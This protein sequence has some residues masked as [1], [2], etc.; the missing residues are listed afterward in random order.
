MRSGIKYSLLAVF[1][2]A[3]TGALISAFQEPD[4]THEQDTDIKYMIGSVLPD[5]TISAGDIN[6]API[7][8]PGTYNWYQGT[9]YC[10]NLVANNH[11]DWRLPTEAELAILY[12]NRATG[13]FSG[14]FND[15]QPFPAGIYWSS[16]NSLQFSNS[17]RVRYFNDGGTG[18]GNKDNG[19]ALIRCVRDKIK[20]SR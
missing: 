16:T 10:T 13:S 11:D 14:T 6:A 5:G 7:D 20:L 15:S 1:A 19:G 2:I 4:E 9:E 17:A 8:A 18:W 3:G 12:N